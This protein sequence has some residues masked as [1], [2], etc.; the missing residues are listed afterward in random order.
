ML[1]PHLYKILSSS[2]IDVGCYGFAVE[3]NPGDPLFKGHFPQRPIL[4]GVCTIQIVKECIGS[5]LLKEM[6]FSNIAQCKFTG[7]IDPA[8]DN[9]LLISV[10]LKTDDFDKTFVDA[11]ITNSNFTV[12]KLKGTLTE[13][14]YGK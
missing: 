9:K 10:T 2:Q 13:A 6:N 5:I 4:P 14:N 7:M 8:V 1:L 3:I 11:V 12:F